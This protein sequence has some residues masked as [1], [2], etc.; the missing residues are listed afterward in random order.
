MAACGGSTM[1]TTNPDSDAP[2]AV[3]SSTQND[4]SAPVSATIRGS[5]VDSSGRLL[6]GVN[7]ECLGNV[8][9]TQP[10]YQPSAQ[11]HQHRIT[12]TGANGA[13]EIVA[14]SLPGTSSTSFMMNAN[15][16]GYDVA[17]QQVSWPGPAC[18][19]SQSRC[20]V[21]V[22]FRLTLASDPAR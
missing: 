8:H 5:V 13:F 2:S 18:S 3:K 7:I 11:G 6:S 14:S 19:S 1:L 9:C 12:Q 22:N 10:D 16:Q 4:A 21:T 17:W 20:T 15:G